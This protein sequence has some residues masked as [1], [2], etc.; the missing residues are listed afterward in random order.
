MVEWYDCEPPKEFQEYDNNKHP[1]GWDG[2]VALEYKSP[3]KELVINDPV[4][5]TIRIDQ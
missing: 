4:Y 3:P 5:G 1:Y 2:T